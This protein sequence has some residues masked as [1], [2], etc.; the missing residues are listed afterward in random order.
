MGSSYNRGK[1]MGLNK[2]AF[3]FTTIAIALSIVVILSFKI[4]N[5]YGLKDAMEVIDTRVDTTNNFIEDLE[6][7]LEKAIF[8]VGFRSLLSLEDYLMNKN[9]P[10]E[11]PKFFGTDLG[12]TLNDAFD[13]VFRLGTI[14]SEK[15][16]LMENN[17]FLN[18]TKKMKEQA[19][20]T[21]I[22]LDFTINGVT[23]SQSEPWK[24]DISVNLKIDVQDKQNIASWTR[25]K[26]FSKKIN[27]TGFVDPLYLVNTDGVANNTIRETIYSN[28]PADLSAHLTNAYYREH[29]DAPNYLDRFENKN[30]GSNGIESLVVGRLKDEGITVSVKSAVDH[31]Y[32]GATSP[33]SCTVLDIA[34]T[35]FLL[36]ETGDPSNT[37][38][39]FYGT[40]CFP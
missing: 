24:V 34:D 35:D 29:M 8:I 1:G 19:N 30:S 10:I 32:F 23:I 39:G 2:K 37:H 11:P 15:M 12:I 33:P 20:K 31:I 3:Y 26:I 40:S 17:T 21:D 36:D 28:W 38:I 5:E 7:D 6:N 14:N 4:N 9:D 22:V 27:I 18:W 16:I 13:E 25:N